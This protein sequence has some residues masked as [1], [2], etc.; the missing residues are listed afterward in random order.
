MRAKDVLAASKTPWSFVKKS[1]VSG[2]LR[3][4]GY[5]VD[6]PKISSVRHAPFDVVQ[7]WE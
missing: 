6:P 5:C 7:D 2:D 3:G 1:A 4:L